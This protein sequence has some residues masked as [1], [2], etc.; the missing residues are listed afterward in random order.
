MPK[1]SEYVDMAASDYL[2]ETESTEL[3]AR[4]IAQY[5]QDSGVQ[6]DYPRLDLI[7]F[8]ALTQKALTKRAEKAAEVTRRQMDKLS[9]LAKGRRH[10]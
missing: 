5:F 10:F 8:Y 6:E 2:Q 3:D 4:W 9:A 1:L 7:A